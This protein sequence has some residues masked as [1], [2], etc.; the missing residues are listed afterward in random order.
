MRYG[1][2]QQV[3]H[4]ADLNDIHHV[5]LSHYH[6]DH[7]S[8]VGVLL[9]SRLVNTQLKKVNK[10]LSIYGPISEQ[11]AKRVEEVPHATFTGY[12]EES[13]LKIGPFTL[14]FKRNMHPVEAYSIKITSGNK[15]IVYTSDTSY[16]EDLVNFA[17]GA[18]LLITECSLYEGMDGISSG[19][20]TSKEAG[21]LAD[22]SE[23]KAVL[24]THLPHYGDLNEL[25]KSAKKEGNFNIRLAEV[26][27]VVGV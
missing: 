5:V 16:T 1:V 19:H 6:Y 21:I 27:M 3:Q 8:D 18:D 25:V 17:S 4:Y 26:G 15:T 2:A 24:L 20:M 14:E 11:M 13:Q 10:P 7:F 12:H 22:K 9:F 23:A